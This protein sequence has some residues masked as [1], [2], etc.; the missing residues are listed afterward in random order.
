MRSI[1]KME[2]I[3]VIVVC[4]LIVGTTLLLHGWRILGFNGCTNL[5]RVNIDKITVTD[6]EVCIDIGPVYTSMGFCT[7]YITKIEDNNLYVGFK[8]HSFIGRDINEIKIPIKG[9]KI[10]KIC[11]KDYNSSK[12]IWERYK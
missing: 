5:N 1:N 2:R 7:G 10:N 4:F 3:F 8:Y 12:L 6:R 11:I 9:V